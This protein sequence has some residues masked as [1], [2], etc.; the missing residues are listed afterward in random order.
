MPGRGRW[1][2]AHEAAF[3]I[4]LVVEADGHTSGPV[5]FTGRS[6]PTDCIRRDVEGIVEGWRFQPATKGGEPVAVHDGRSF[7][8]PR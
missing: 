4:Q 1:R 6:Q 8:S 2:D 7:N 3:A 5:R